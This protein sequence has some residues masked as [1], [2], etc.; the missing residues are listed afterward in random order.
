MHSI[1]DSSLD[2]PRDA[3]SW[4]ARALAFASEQQMLEATQAFARAATLA[5][6]DFG[7][8]AGYAQACYAS[9]LPSAHLFMR[10]IQLAPGNPEIIQRTAVALA[11]REGAR[12]LGV[13][14]QIGSLEP[15]KAADLV[16]ID[17]KTVN[18]TP[19][20]D[21]V[22]AL[23]TAMKT[24]NVRSVMCAGRWLLEDGEIAVVDEHEVLAEAQRRAEAVATRAG[25][26]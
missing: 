4:H 23:V 19:L 9:G 13:A 17:P 22:S 2:E 8:A 3:A 15:G 5:P 21:P 20:H 16:L 6:A 12:A 14:E 1:S 11:T 25:L 7:I 10:A 18:M 26:R 24:E